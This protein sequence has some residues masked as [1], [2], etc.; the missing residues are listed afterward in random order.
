MM[1]TL[2][3]VVLEAAEVAAYSIFWRYLVNSLA[4]CVRHYVADLA[5]VH[6]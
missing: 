6:L 3:V 5:L 4:P 1:Y 2:R